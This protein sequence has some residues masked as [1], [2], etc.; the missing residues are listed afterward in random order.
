[1]YGDS[2]P[3]LHL[4]FGGWSPCCTLDCVQ[5]YVLKQADYY[6][7]KHL[8]LSEKII[9]L[10]QCNKSYSSHIKLLGAQTNA[11]SWQELSIWWVAPMHGLMLRGFK[12]LLTR[13][14][15]EIGGRL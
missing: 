9:Y 5:V 13:T 7:L 6:L 14:H 4:E 10:S 12:A 11:S 2:L 15:G 3:K 8:G 1:M